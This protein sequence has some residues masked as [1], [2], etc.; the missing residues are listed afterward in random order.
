M[1][2]GPGIFLVETVGFGLP[3]DEATYSFTFDKVKNP[4]KHYDGRTTP[5]GT[6]IF[7]EKGKGS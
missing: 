4:H 2:F 6:A 3:D 5:N 1:Q 7:W